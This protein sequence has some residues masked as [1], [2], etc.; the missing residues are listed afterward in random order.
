M[1]YCFTMKDVSKSDIR[2]VITVNFT[3]KISNDILQLQLHALE[4]NSLSRKA[5]PSMK[6]TRQPAIA[7]SEKQRYFFIP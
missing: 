6:R 3:V 2:M 1:H 4:L 5:I 7:S